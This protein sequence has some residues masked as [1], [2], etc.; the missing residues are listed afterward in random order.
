MAGL[1][2]PTTKSIE[3]HSH[4]NEMCVLGAMILS[5]KAIED[6]RPVVTGEM[7]F[8]KYNG[9]I[10]EAIMKLHTAGT[11][12]D[13]VTLK[14]EMNE[15]KVLMRAGGV[16]YLIQVAESVPTA[17]NALHYARK[18]RDLWIRRESGRRVR[19]VDRLASNENVPISTLLENMRRLDEG[20]NLFTN[21]STPPMDMVTFGEDFTP[22]EV[23]YLWEPYLPKGKAVFVDA[24]GGTGKT[25]WFIA[26][27]AGL[28]VGALPMGGDCDPMKTA[29]FFRDADLEEEYETVYRANGGKAGFISYKKDDRYL[30]RGFADEMV[31][32][33]KAN[34]IAI[35]CMDPFFHFLP[36]AVNLNDGQAVLPYCNLVNYVAKKTNT[37][38]LCVRHVGK[39]KMGVSAASELGLGSQMLRNTL[40]GQIV[41]RWHPE[42]RGV[43]VVTDEKGS[44]LIPRG[45][46]F[47]FR[48]RGLVIE[49]LTDRCGEDPF[50][51]HQVGRPATTMATVTTWLAEFLGRGVRLRSD[52]VDAG[53]AAGF[54]RI[55][56][57]RA[58]SAIKVVKLRQGKAVQWS[59][60]PFEV[61]E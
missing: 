19:E 13:F 7:F 46:A 53:V 22:V 1:E 39:G 49:Y 43:V 33:I 42:E 18:V 57:D 35:W 28:S 15:R 36:G 27:A 48:R 59:L 17:A 54:T 23:D 32:T 61:G 41:M 21:G 26:L 20:F 24:D 6:I 40:R 51:K 55:S 50:D 45:D 58:A 2:R 34:G 47:Q 10:F 5:A 60:D 9:I 31:A 52:C 37:T 12:I 29:L 16:E 11:A 30:D 4:E 8:N 44:I 56:I 38:G 25:S 3:L 14:T